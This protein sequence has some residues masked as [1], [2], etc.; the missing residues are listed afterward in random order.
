MSV[1]ENDMSVHENGMSASKSERLRAPFQYF[2]GKGNMLTKLLPLLPPHKVYV[3][4]FCG[5]ASLFFAKPP[6]PVEVLNDL[7]EDV[8][9]VFRVLQNKET[10]E[11]LRFRLMY[12]PYARA[13]FVRAIEMLKQ[14]DLTPVDRAW[15]F[16]V[17]QNMGF[18]GGIRANAGDW[19]RA[20]T[21]NQGCADVCNS[22]LMRLSMLDAW[23]WRLMTV[24]I[25][26]RDA[27]EVI[28][29]WDSPDTL[30][31]VDP[32]YVAETRKT[33]DAYAYE[34]TADQHK[35]LVE[36]L[37]G[38]K[39]KAVVSGYEHPLYSPFAQSGWKVHK[40]HTACH[41][42]G[43]IRQNGLQGDGSALA[44]VPRTEVVWVKE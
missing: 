40:F 12:T 35:E 6:S 25:D 3:E 4:P 31:Y 37:L 24:Q 32:P 14:K 13:E 38:I 33:L 22:W 28:R 39:G 7:N 43:R 27:L 11:E 34:M 26:C 2:G 5:A 30:F 8:V 9:N 41:A 20:F 42:A 1:H 44:K 10:H 19:S 15:A 36:S 16:M 17:K 29:Y 18:S 21:S 23:R